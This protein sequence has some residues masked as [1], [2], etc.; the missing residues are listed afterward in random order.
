MLTTITTPCF[1]AE[2]GVSWTEDELAFMEEHP[3]IR[4]G[5]DPGFVPF[6]FIDED[7]EY[8][9]IAADY[10]ALIS[11]KT[12]LQFEVVKG[13]TWPEAY[14]M[15]LAGKVDVL[16]A[17][18]KTKEREEQFLFSKPYYYYKRVIVTRDTDT[19]ISGID[20]LKG[21]T[22]AV[23]R[24][25][26]HHSYLLSYQNINLSLYDSVEA[27]LTAVATGT[28]K[29]FIGNLATTNYLIR[30]NGLTN[31]RFVSFEAEKQQALHFAVRKDWP[32]LVNIFNKAL[33]TI[34]ESEKLAI[35][36]KWVELDTDIDYGLL[37]VFYPSSAL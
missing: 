13:L 23:Q 8:K 26:S 34:T 25:S 14:D 29:A 9:G 20:D 27:A 2:N 12:G 4:L 5:V 21:F 6:E 3:V 30:L 22:V 17:I 10:L 18:G 11:E 28:E 19:E 35:N 7:G 32:E 33:G 24:N 16:P 36:N 31:L 15:A 1:A 37:F